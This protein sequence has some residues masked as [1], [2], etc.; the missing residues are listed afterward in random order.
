MDARF[1]ELSSR[2]ATIELD[3]STCVLLRHYQKSVAE[4]RVRLEKLQEV[5]DCL[6]KVGYLAPP[7]FRG[8]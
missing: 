5:N 7:G 1:E 4:Y 2:V 6:H 8:S 3:A